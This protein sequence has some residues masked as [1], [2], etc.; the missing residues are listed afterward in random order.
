MCVEIL[1][2]VQT[3]FEPFLFLFVSSLKVMNNVDSA[4]NNSK[5]RDKLQT[6]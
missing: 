6:V 2:I 1:V 5:K 4:I 3:E